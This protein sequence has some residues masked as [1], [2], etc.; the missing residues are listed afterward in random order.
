MCS[1]ETRACQKYEVTLR[2]QDTADDPGSQPQYRSNLLKQRII[3]L[4]LSKIKDGLRNECFFYLGWGEGG[5]KEK[6]K[7]VQ[8][9]KIC[10]QILN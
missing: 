4:A 1:D 9:K 8:D 7:Q 6:K 10:K 3:S 2:G 5:D